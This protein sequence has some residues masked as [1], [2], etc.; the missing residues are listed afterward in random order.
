MFYLKGG[1]GKM[2]WLQKQN[3]SDSMVD[4]RNKN[5]PQQKGCHS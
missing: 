1:R 2:M 3:V 5:K 4:Y